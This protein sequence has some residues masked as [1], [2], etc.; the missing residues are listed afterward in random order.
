LASLPTDEYVPARDDR[1]E[2]WPE[3]LLPVTVFGRLVM[4]RQ[5]GMGA[6]A[7]PI[8]VIESWARVHDVEDIAGLVDKI[9]AMDA[10]Y[11]NW[12]QEKQERQKTEQERPKLIMPK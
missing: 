6:S 9:V 3:N 11:L 8:P 1:P 2:L 10:E 7:I 4:Q 5:I 12:A